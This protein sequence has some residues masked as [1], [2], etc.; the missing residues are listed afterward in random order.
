M[1]KSP[2]RFN[3]EEID[4]ALLTLALCSGTS[5]RASAELGAVGIDVDQSTLHRWRTA[6]HTRRYERLYKEQLPRIGERVALRC[7][8]LAES[9]ADLAARLVRAIDEKLPDIPARDLPGALRNVETA[10]AINVDK[11]A[12]LR[13]KP[14][15]IVERRDAG[16][17][18]RR[19][20]ALGVID[21][22][23]E[24]EDSPSL[25]PGPAPGGGSLERQAPTP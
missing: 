12:L 2:A 8:E 17:L 16:E 18:I 7:E 10:K 11:S 25:P 3:D 5:R 20:N 23:A 24:E 21:S 13:G 9:Q 1:A 14:T 22:T 6:L 19:L 15:Q 4:T